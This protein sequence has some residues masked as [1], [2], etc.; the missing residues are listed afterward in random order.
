MNTYHTLIQTGLVN[1]KKRIRSCPDTESEQAIVRIAVVL[2]L[3]FYLAITGTFSDAGPNNSTYLLLTWTSVLTSLA[4][5]LWILF[6]PKKSV[7]RR[8]VGIALDNAY[9]SVMMFFGQA[10]ATPVFG[11]Y[12]WVTLGNGF[13]YGNTYLFASMLLSV[14]F[15]SLVYKYNEYWSQSQYYAWGVL[16]SLIVLPLYASKLVRHLRVAIG[17]AEK[18]NQAKTN[19]LAN[20][21][22][23][24]RTPLNGVIGMTDLLVGTQLNREQKDF[25][26]TIQA[27]ANAL[28]SLVEDILD[29]S[30]IEVGKLVIQSQ[31][32]DLHM[33][34]KNT[35]K[36]LEPQASDKG[37]YLKVEISPNVPIAV[38]ADP[39]L[40]RQV[41]I[42][43]IGNAIKFTEQGGI[44]V[45][46]NRLEEKPNQLMSLRFEVIDTGVGIPKEVQDKVFDTFTQ[47]DES[48][49]RR[50]GGT[51]LGTAISKQL[52]ELMGGEI[53]L[54]SSP[55][56]GSRF[57]F[58]LDFALPTASAETVSEKGLSSKKLLV[59]QSTEI[60]PGL[61]AVA[62]PWLRSAQIAS[63]DRAA[64]EALKEAVIA[65]D[66]YDLVLVNTADADNVQFAELVKGDA[67]LKNTQLILVSSSG[68][69]RKTEIYTRAGYRDVITAPVDVALLFNTLHNALVEEIQ[70][71]PEVSKLAN[72]FPATSKVGS[73]DI[74]VAEDNLVN[75]KVAT[76]ILERAGH[77]VELVQNGQEALDKLEEK[78]YDLTILDMQMPVMGGIDAIKLFRFSRIESKMPF[79]MLTANATIEAINEC[80]DIGVEAYVTKPFQARKLIDTIDQVAQKHNIVRSVVEKLPVKKKE[81]VLPSTDLTKLAELASLSYESRFLEE[82]VYSFLKDGANLIDQMKQ[83][84]AEGEILRMKEVAHAFKG[85]AASLGATRL[86]D[87]GSKLSSLTV[88][89]FRENG[90]SLISQAESEFAMV[91]A[92]LKNYLEQQQVSSIH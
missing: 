52:I 29:I 80:K 30:K 38:I 66:P 40:L 59:L 47:A 64:L 70:E 89:G 32:C 68:D 7:L 55:G 22:H 45:R 19:F 82:L 17:K 58:A 27:S 12:L 31:E 57:W 91:S 72:Y 11:V 26:H 39:Q 42:N 2:V 85:S 18:A 88:A 6:D 77:R 76:K 60:Q 8:V 25:V 21:S 86:Y 92:E 14:G 51:G 3:F 73:L 83:A 36:M 49:T 56:Q 62:S 84:L 81:E 79:I 50:Y 48:V 63:S 61:H 87:T 24:I 75:Q 65:K 90:E 5:F 43:L 1:L 13:R 9:I 41:L 4:I 28:L 10:L 34:V 16:V 37:L 33:L 67:E 44:E 54:Q 78:E 74:L 35:A 69:S 15:F 23:E 20:M 71:T 46:V 53:R